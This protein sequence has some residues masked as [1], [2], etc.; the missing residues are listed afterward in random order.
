[1]TD[2]I[3]ELIEELKES[4]GIAMPK[5]EYFGYIKGIENHIT[6]LQQK[7]ERLNNIINK[8]DKWLDLAIEIFD[9]VDVETLELVKRK[10]QELK[11][12]VVDNE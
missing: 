3:K 10:L 12:D 7:N 2:E 9:N 11:G 4:Y 5:Q 1:M 8:F 6:N